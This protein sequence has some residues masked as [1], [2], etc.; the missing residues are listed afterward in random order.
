MHECVA[1][2][3]ARPACA[4]LYRLH[5]SAPAAGAG[6]SCYSTCFTCAQV[7]AVFTLGWARD[8]PHLL[9]V[10]GAK[11]SVTVWDVRA[12]AGVAGKFSGLLPAHA[13]GQAAAKEDA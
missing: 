11:G 7:G 2:V 9:A 3:G 4:I 13:R 10:G 12:H 8:A 6:A 5:S 1:C